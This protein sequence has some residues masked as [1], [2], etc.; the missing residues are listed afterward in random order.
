MKKALILG[1]LAGVVVVIVLIRFFPP[2][3]DFNLDNPFWNGL[4]EFQKETNAFSLGD[5]SSVDSVPF[6]SE[7]SL[8]II[9]PSG[10]YSDKEISS[11]SKYLKAGGVLIL[12]DDFGSGNA[13]LEGLGLKTRFSQHLVVDPLFRG[14]ASVLAK[15][16]D[17][18]APLADI[19]SLMFNYATSLKF[20]DSEGKI[21]A[22]S[23][24]FSYF[25]DNLNGEREKG[26]DEGP[27][28]MIAEIS[29][30]NG[31]IYLISDSSLFINSMLG[32]EENR[33]FL[34]NIIK[35]K[36]GFIDISHHPM[37]PLPNL[38]KVEVKIYQIASRFEVRYSIFLILVIVIV[39]IKFKRGK[40]RYGEDMQDILQKHPD[41]DKKI[42][43]DI[44]SSRFEVENKRKGG[45]NE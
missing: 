32:E 39:W 13:I 2:N 7:T 18:S 36:K 19:K 42:L 43:K 8:F 1:I 3:D 40:V 41:W 5:I 28:P 45:K 16:V 24:S 9:G 15:T 35:G 27:F 26:E 11:V 6:P 33:G 12:A 21:L 29:Y 14:K 10:I 44:L 20:N 17:L 38:K 25:D 30:E 23:S 4:K 31:K 22:T 34:K 37:G